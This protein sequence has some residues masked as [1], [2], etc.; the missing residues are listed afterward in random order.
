[1]IG[2]LAIK[3]PP[4]LEITTKKLLKIKELYLSDSIEDAALAFDWMAQLVGTKEAAINL[5]MLTFFRHWKEDMACF[6]NNKNFWEV[7]I[8][9]SN[10]E[11]YDDVIYSAELKGVYGGMELVNEE[12]PYELADIL[13][14]DAKMLL[15]NRLSAR[16]TGAGFR[17]YDGLFSNEIN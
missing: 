5:Y 2:N 10:K 8:K 6:L 11:G 17:L 16:F 15:Y 12:H 14:G 3:E 9:A 4:S 1:M 7:K 13:R